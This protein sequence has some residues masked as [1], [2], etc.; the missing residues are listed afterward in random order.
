M[1]FESL[2]EGTSL[3][4]GAM[5]PFPATLP[6]V[7]GTGA[8][9]GS[10][11]GSEP[12]AEAFAELAAARGR[13]LDIEAGVWVE[14]DEPSGVVEIHDPR[15][16]RAGR[17]AFA[18]ALAA[19][20]IEQ[21]QALQVEIDLSFSICRMAFAAGEFDRSELARRAAAAVTAATPAL[22]D[23]RGADRARSG[24]PLFDL[25]LAG[26]SLTMAVAG[27]V[28]PGIPALP[29]LVL[30]ARHAARLSPDLDR[31]LRRQPWACALLSQ[32]R[33]ES[34]LGLDPRCLPR[35]LLASGLAA[36]VFLI[37]HPPLPV[38]MVVELGMMALVCLRAA[39]GPND[40]ELAV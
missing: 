29:F 12:R 14:C 16:F 17:E 30:A 28:L 38:V 6:L 11:P 1:S 18:R 9:A 10:L 2:L 7:P 26:G 31:I 13:R 24:R 37:V 20:A 15:L 32:V 33:S 4:G 27:A 23:R 34:L 22:V 19:A 39:G 21:F 3:G 35:V 5:L 25:A 8:D 40:V 36:A